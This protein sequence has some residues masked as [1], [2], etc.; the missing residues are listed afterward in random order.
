[1]LPTSCQSCSSQ[2][3]LAPIAVSSWEL[4][5]TPLQPLLLDLST[6]SGLGGATE[7]P[8]LSG[9]ASMVLL[10]I[11]VFPPEG[12]GVGMVMFSKLV[13]FPDD[14]GSACIKQ[15]MLCQLA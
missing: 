11:P 6:A 12:P 1:M 2:L 8:G 9:T 10:Y 14:E 13:G 4:K 7:G 3:K 15:Q 5:S